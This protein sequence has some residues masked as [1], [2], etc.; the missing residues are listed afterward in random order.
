MQSFGERTSKASAGATMEWVLAGAILAAWF[1]FRAVKNKERS[2]HALQLREFATTPSSVDKDLSETRAREA[3]IDPRINPD[4]RFTDGSDQ[5]DRGLLALPPPSRDRLSAIRNHARW[6]PPGESVRVGGI[7]IDAGMFYLGGA[8]TG[9]ISDRE[10]NCLV[11]PSCA[12]APSG[13]DQSGSLLPYWPSYSNIPPV[14]RRTY[15][16]WLPSGR[17][18]PRIGIGYVFLSFYG[19]ERRM[20]VD[21]VKDETPAL[22]AEVRRLLALHGENHSFRNYASKFLDV[23]DLVKG[24][25]ISRPV[26]SPELRNGYEMPLSV[27]LHLGRKLASATS[28]DGT[29]ALLWVLSL[30]DTYLRTPAT[31]CFD[32]LAELWQM[33]FASR[34][35]LGLKVNPPKTKL[36][37][38]Y[39]AASGGFEC[40]LDLSDSETGPLPDIAAVSAPLDGLRDLLNARTDELASYSRLLG[41]QTAL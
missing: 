14:A 2:V 41:C 36:K 13:S 18:D 5:R 25:E 7:S 4:P 9:S 31:R 37:I 39:H 17:K 40:S 28:F 11:D 21:A 32:E 6:I 26:L 30:P 35:P 33:R 38:E 19:L 34:Y 3:W 15:L 27:R 22:I 29:D 16:D 24:P 1:V 12:I 10:N 8:F 20:L 23:A